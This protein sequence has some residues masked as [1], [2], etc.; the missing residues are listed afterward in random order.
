MVGE[1]EMLGGL[2]VV[3]E[4]VVINGIVAVVAGSDARD[5]GGEEGKVS[6]GNVSIAVGATDIFG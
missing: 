2:G 1:V 3:V 6:V 5:N 4:E